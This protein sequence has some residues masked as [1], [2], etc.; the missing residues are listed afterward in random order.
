[1]LTNQYREK[2]KKMKVEQRAKHI[3]KFLTKVDRM[4]EAIKSESIEKK[5]KVITEAF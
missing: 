1:M 2:F 4:I 3:T 5:I